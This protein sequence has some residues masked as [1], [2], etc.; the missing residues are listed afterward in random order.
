MSVHLIRRSYLINPIDR[1]TLILSLFCDSWILVFQP[2]LHCGT[3]LLP[4]LL[5]WLLRRESPFLQILPHRANVKGDLE[6]SL[7]EIP[8]CCSRPQDKR[9]P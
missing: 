2:P 9:H 1:R 3:T 6:F 5:N 8:D 4:S 7:N